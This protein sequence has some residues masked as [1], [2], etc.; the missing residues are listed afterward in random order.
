MSDGPDTSDPEDDATAP[1]EL[2]DVAPRPLDS[3][4]GRRVRDD[5]RAR[6]FGDVSRADGKPRA[7]ERIGRYEVL[8]KLGQGG[9]GVVY[10]CRD[11]TLDREVAIKV[12]RPRTSGAERLRREAQ[13]LARLTDAHIVT[14]YDVGDH[15]GGVFVAMELVDGVTL[16]TWRLGRDPAAGRD[17]A[18]IVDAYDQA[19]RGLAAA[20]RA[21]LVHR[22]FKPDNVMVGRD[23]RVRV[24]DFGLARGAAL[25]AL[26]EAAR[27]ADGGIEAAITATGAVLGT[28]A[29]MAPEQ[30]RGGA[31]DARADQFAFAVALFEALV[32]R[33]PFPGSTLA[34]IDAAMHEGPPELPETLPRGLRE[35]LARGLA[36]APEDRFADMEAL[37]TALR[38]AVRP[39]RWQSAA[40]VAGAAVLGVVVVLAQRTDP[41]EQATAP[42]ERVWDRDA[43]AATRRGADEPSQV[44]ITAIDRHVAAWRVEALAVC[45]GEGDDLDLRRGCLDDTLASIESAVSSARDGSPV[46][47]MLTDDACVAVRRRGAVPSRSRPDQASIVAE[48]RAAVRQT[49]AAGAAGHYALAATTI[50]PAID[51]AR[52]LGDPALLAEALLLGAA[53]DSARGDHRT[54]ERRAHE[55]YDVALAGGID[56]LALRAATDLVQYVGNEQRRRDDGEQ[57]ARTAETH[58]ARLPEADP[59]RTRLMINRG[60]MRL[61]LGQLEAA[62]ADLELARSRYVESL[63]P[64]NALQLPVLSNLAHLRFLAG[65]LAG[66][67]ELMDTA[68]AIRER[69]DGVDHP[70]LVSLL[71]NRSVVTTSQER[72]DLAHA[73]LVRAAATCAASD[74][75]AELPAVQLNLADVAYER[76]RFVEAREHAEAAHIGFARVFGADHPKVYLARMRLGVVATLQGDLTLARDTLLAVVTSAEALLGAA[77]PVVAAAWQLL[78]RVE[79]DAG[80]LVAARRALDRAHSDATDAAPSCGRV[81]RATLVATLG[82]A[83]E[84]VAP[85]EAVAVLEAV[86]DAAAA[87][88]MP[89]RADHELALARALASSGAPPSVFRPLAESARGRWAGRGGGWDRRAASVDAWLDT[90]DAAP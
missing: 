71:S 43:A 18:A 47:A 67:L 14:V 88:T 21:G 52:T 59:A 80:D 12:M 82:L 10:A 86:R 60:L 41:C 16:R 24:L 27:S 76:G 58:S 56:R 29:Y 74:L 42:I 70:D 33:R 31:V 1:P 25:A 84:T 68:I 48:V 15:D 9:T 11:P 22:D 77:D 38:I 39:R 55:A 73:D 37:R 20:H 51:R 65:D 78:A 89:T 83:A 28:P 8:R 54:A 85:T 57:W 23:R 46:A 87:C 3:A 63:G 36:V 6:L 61:E 81:Q 13:I 66:A 26:G 7:P 64:D 79:L 50:A 34:A 35:V 49:I 30:L 45:R 19:A 40:A 17:L 75:D 5:M 2:S 32:G 44:Q 4:Q 72:F 53:T 69:E 62:T 90:V